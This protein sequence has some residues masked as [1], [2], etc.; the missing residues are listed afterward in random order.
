MSEFPH[1]LADNP[2]KWEEYVRS[3][4]AP[5]IATA[6]VGTVVMTLVAEIATWLLRGHAAADGRFGIVFPWV[7]VL[8][9]AVTALVSQRQMRHQGERRI[10]LSCWAF[11]TL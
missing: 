7:L 11:G 2:Q 6:I 9:I 1:R 3:F 4:D 10:P 8:A 5:M